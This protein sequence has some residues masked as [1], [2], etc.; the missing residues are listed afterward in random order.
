MRETTKQKNREDA[1]A[2]HSPAWPICD[3]ITHRTFIDFG[4]IKPQ[5]PRK[6]S[7]KIKAVANGIEQAYYISLLLICRLNVFIHNCCLRPNDNIN[8]TSNKS[9]QKKYNH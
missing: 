8:P 9:L 6:N 4:N 3:N 7:D 2:N 1:K 5:P